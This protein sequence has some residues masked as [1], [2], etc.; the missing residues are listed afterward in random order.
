[1]V[2]KAQL[3]AQYKYDKAN[4][5]QIVLKLNTK[6]DSDILAKLQSEN[7]KQGYI[8]DLIR[9]NMRN[10]G[11]VLSLD[12]IRYLLLPIAK[13][14]ELRSVTL[15]GSYARNEATPI[16][17]VDIIVDGGNFAGLVEYMNML[18][19]METALG[20]NVDVITMSSLDSNNSPADKL[21]KEQIE[22]D[23]VIL[24]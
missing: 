24:I 8:K 12:S 22:R 5:Q 21:F 16:S 9:K 7:N 19:D 17:D 1:M 3:N 14:Y 2:T 23:K 20:R 18:K 15:F 11:D 13:Q 10:T 4:T 6:S